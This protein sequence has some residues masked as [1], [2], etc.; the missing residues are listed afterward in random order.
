MINKS[1]N[2]NKFYASVCCTEYIQPINLLLVFFNSVWYY[3][4]K[5]VFVLFFLE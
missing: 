3:F 4:V 1:K 2:L 5:N